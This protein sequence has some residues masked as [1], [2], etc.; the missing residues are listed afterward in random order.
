[1]LKNCPQE[2]KELQDFTKNL[3]NIKKYRN[4]KDY[5]QI[6]MKGNITRIK[7]HRVQQYLL[8]KQATTMMFNKL[9]KKAIIHLEKAKKHGSDA[10]GKVH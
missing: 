7:A 1:M 6:K 5:S 10:H 8:V 2:N 4:S 3:H 9:R